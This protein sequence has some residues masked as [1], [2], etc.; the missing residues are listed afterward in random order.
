M[1][2]G[3]VYQ[4]ALIVCGVGA[5]GWGVAIALMNWRGYRRKVTRRV[6]ILSS[7]N[8]PHGTE[9]RFRAVDEKGEM[10]RPHRGG[11]WPAGRPEKFGDRTFRAGQFV[12]LDY[13]PENPLYL[14][15]PGRYPRIHSWGIPLGA[16]LMGASTTAI[17]IVS[18]SQ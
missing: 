18:F 17:G 10:S 4:V 13:D 2:P 6:E 16:L 3:I 8:M 12:T 11:E 9:Y 5:M 1:I 7:I 14:Y 15:P